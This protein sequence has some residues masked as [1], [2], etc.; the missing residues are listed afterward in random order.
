MENFKKRLFSLVVALVLSF[1][2]LGGA[3]A[4]VSAAD[5]STTETTS[6]YVNV[7][8]DTMNIESDLNTVHTARI[9]AETSGIASY[10][11]SI[12]VPQSLRVTNVRVS[13]EMS[14]NETDSF[15]FVYTDTG[16]NV[17]Y[18]SAYSYAGNV[19]LMYVDFELN[20][21]GDFITSFS[22]GSDI[23]TFFVDD[24]ANDVNYGIYFGDIY[25]SAKQEQTNLKGDVD[26]NGYINLQDLIQLQR[27]IIE[28]VSLGDDL[29]YVCDINN[30]GSINVKDCQYI[31]MY[32]VGE[33]SSLE[34][35]GGGS[36]TVDTY[37]LTIMVYDQDGNKFHS[38]ETRA[39]QGQT[40]G[41]VCQ[42]LFEK[43][44]RQYNITA[45]NGVSSN[46]YGRYESEELASNLTIN[47]NDIVCVYVTISNGN[48]EVKE[49]SVTF[50]VYM[51]VNGELSNMAT[52][53]VNVREGVLINEYVIEYFSGMDVVAFYDQGF[54]NPVVEN[55]T[56][57]ENITI[58]VIAKTS[59]IDG[60]YDLYE[61]DDYGKNVAVGKLSFSG[62]EVQIVYGDKKYNATYVNMSGSI[63]A[64][65]DTFV[66]FTFYQ[67]EG[68]YIL[69]YFFDG[70]NYETVEELKE[71]QG[72]KQVLITDGPGLV[73]AFF[74]D[75]GVWEMELAGIIMY[76]DYELNDTGVTLYLFGR[77]QDFILNDKGIWEPANNGGSED[78]EANVYI[79]VLNTRGEEIARMPMNEDDGAPYDN[80]IWN[81]LRS[82]GFETEMVTNIYSEQ[83]GDITK[84]YYDFYVEGYDRIEITVD[85]NMGGGETQS[86]YYNLYVLYDMGGQYVPYDSYTQIHISQDEYLYEHV[87]NNM[88]DEIAGAYVEM[89]ELYYDYALT[90]PVEKSDMVSGS[91]DVYVVVSDIEIEGKFNIVG[92]DE[93][94]ENK[95]VMGTVE[96]TNGTAT[97][98][99]NDQSYSGPYYKMYRGIEVRTGEYSQILLSIYGDEVDFDAMFDGSDFKVS[100]EFTQIA[101]TYNVNMDYAPMEMSL[102]LCNNGVAKLSVGKVCMMGRY[103]LTD[104]GIILYMDEMMGAADGLEF[105]YD[106]ETNSFIAQN[107]GGNDGPSAEYP[108]MSYDVESAFGS[109]ISMMEDG[110]SLVIN[111]NGFVYTTAMGNQ[112]S[113]TQISAMIMPGQMGQVY[114][115]V[116]DGKGY[117]VMLD[118]AQ[119]YFM[120]MDSFD[121]SNIQVVPE[122]KEMAGYYAYVVDGMNLGSFELGE[123]GIAIIY[124]GPF[125]AK[126]AYVVVDAQTIACAGGEYIIDRAS[127]TI[128]PNMG[129]SDVPSVDQPVEFITYTYTDVEGNTYWIDIRT[130]G[131]FFVKSTNGME[132]NGKY[133]QMSEVDYTL[134]GSQT[135]SLTI[136]MDG[137]V[138]Y[139]E[140]IAMSDSTITI[141]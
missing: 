136:T 103:S 10:Q 95:Y 47:A 127:R 60:E 119:G 71:I 135:Y 110:S 73:S 76:N 65:V 8:S 77:P 19:D 87:M 62:E 3:I 64:T 91:V 22:H 90:R 15:S 6:S 102:I 138:S 112:E 93:S 80:I 141:K 66:Q 4:T 82:F 133:R 89:G 52:V 7:Y 121:V 79:V 26:F 85:T 5:Y 29:I 59:S 111:E 13:E 78:Y 120:I 109:Y 41:E 86:T 132:D 100:D 74:Y 113:G 46:V 117:T 69:N 17:I 118:I 9:Y 24:K 54:S 34:N 125:M 42:P 43:L 23:E 61:R 140:I 55:D 18:S 25:V 137:G 106:P 96:F 36:G 40:Y 11:I 92:Y 33:L 114:L 53:P 94:Y 101:G 2:A 38:V 51:E 134:Y 70:S 139:F 130:D 16:F 126:S 30:D 124:N 63:I 128:T 81:A 99:I 67:Y 83:H 37:S 57:K 131:T 115:G 12:D 72:E 88:K 105:T 122:H 28:N 1:S 27:Y 45:Y 84:N 107:M 39:K 123:D 50:E 48:E 49:I 35:I 75:N 98:N 129:G 58:Y 44:E 14:K 116:N 31:Q 32:L 68:M 97:V 104:T 56:F 21:G 20:H 108:E